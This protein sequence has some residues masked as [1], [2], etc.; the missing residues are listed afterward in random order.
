LTSEKI[1]ELQ[2][3]SKEHFKDLKKDNPGGAQQ[4]HCIMVNDG[5]SNFADTIPD[6]IQKKFG[7]SE[8]EIQ[9]IYD[10]QMNSL[11]ESVLVFQLGFL[12]KKVIVFPINFHNS[13]WGGHICFQLR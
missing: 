7:N 11:V 3:L 10:R 9:A 12:E 2:E 13:H 8:N 6:L 5:L 4:A 1:K